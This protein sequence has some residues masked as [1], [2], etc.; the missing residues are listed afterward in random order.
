MD[1]NVEE[2]LNRR[3]SLAQIKANAEIKD[4]VGDIMGLTEDET[5]L[6]SENFKQRLGGS[7][8][9]LLKDIGLN[10]LEVWGAAV[11]S[12]NISNAIIEVYRERG[13]K[14]ITIKE[15]YGLAILLDIASQRLKERIKGLKPSL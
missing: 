6:V 7:G 3:I 5:T 4:I 10:K 13:I 11:I 8:T 2:I 14:E 12:N 9:A 1:M 15:A